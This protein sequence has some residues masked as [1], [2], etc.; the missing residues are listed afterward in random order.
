MNSVDKTNYYMF[1]AKHYVLVCDNFYFQED[2]NVSENSFALFYGKFRTC[3]PRVKVSFLTGMVQSS[4]GL[5]YCVQCQIEHL[6]P[7]LFKGWMTLSS[8]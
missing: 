5:K 6:R 2:A 3:A 7:Q 8:G 4:Y 1:F